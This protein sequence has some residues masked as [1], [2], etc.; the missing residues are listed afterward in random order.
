MEGTAIFSFLNTR[1]SIRAVDRVAPEIGHLFF[2]G[3]EITKLTAE[4][5]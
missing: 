3:K 2:N 5:Q 4:G 1:G